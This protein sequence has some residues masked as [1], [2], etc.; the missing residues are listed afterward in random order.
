MINVNS[1]FIY[2]YHLENDY[3]S[4]K[5]SQL[6][7]PELLLLKFNHHHNTKSPSDNEKT[8]EQF[9]AIN[10]FLLIGTHI[11]SSIAI[12]ILENTTT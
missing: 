6:N 11:T 9:A 2:F 3:H 7:A 8:L 4:H 10:N 12:L 5:F 1:F